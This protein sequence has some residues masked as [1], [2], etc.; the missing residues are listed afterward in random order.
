MPNLIASGS[1]IQFWSRTLQR[2]HH[3]K[4]VYRAIANFAEKE[5]ILTKGQTFNRPY[6]TKVTT[7]PVGAGGSYTRQ[8]VT[9]TNEQLTINNEDEATFYFKD[10][11]LLQNSYPLGA[12]FATDCASVLSNLIDGKVFGEY[13][14]ADSSID[15]GDIGGVSGDGLTL[16]VSNVLQMFT[17][18]NRKLSSLNVGEEDRWV[19]MSYQF[20][21]KL[22]EYLGGKESQLG[23]TVGK[24]GHIGEYMNMRCYVSNA[25]GWSGRL[26][27]GT[28]PT[29]GD[30]VVVNGVTFTWKT[31]LGST[32]GNIH[33]CS[34]AAKSLTNLVASLNAPGTSVDSG[35][36]AGF[37]AVSAADQILLKNITATDGVTYM[38]LKANGKGYVTVSETLS[39]AADIWTTTKQIQHILFGQGKPIDVVIQKYPKLE[40]HHRD[41]YIGKDFVTWEMYGI[42]TFDEGD[43]QLIDCKIRSDGF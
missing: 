32:A 42:K 28:N 16:T 11:D 8:D 19:V 18:G 15:D 40:I 4:D 12:S 7:N 37:V 27:F 43:T 34:T 22:L 30:T 41:G 14:Q 35:T 33:I 31:T 2:I 26:E 39:A 24:N 36:D 29:D 5:G 9:V 23:D 20:R 38:T 21:E 1:F 6:K 25:L 10:A 17:I 3:V 13:D